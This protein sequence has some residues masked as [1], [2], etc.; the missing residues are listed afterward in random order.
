MASVLYLVSDAFTIFGVS[1]ASEGHLRAGPSLNPLISCAV[2]S[3]LDTTGGDIPESDSRSRNMP[4]MII[5]SELRPSQGAQDFFVKSSN[6][7]LA[8]RAQ[9]MTYWESLRAVPDC[10]N[11]KRRIQL[12]K[13]RTQKEI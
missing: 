2:V 6:T 12:R 9:R 10:E 13:H 7:C 11:K 4:E 5:V 8:V 3:P 1:I